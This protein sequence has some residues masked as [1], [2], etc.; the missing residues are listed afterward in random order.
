MKRIVRIIFNA[1]T[2]ILCWLTIS[3]IFYYLAGKWGMKKGKLTLMLVSPLFIIGYLIIL[4]WGYVTYLDY[5][6]KYYFTDEDRIERITGV[7][8]PDMDIVEYDKDKSGFTGDYSDRLLLEFEKIPSE[9]AYQTLDSLIETG[10]T[11]WRMNDSVYVF[12]ATWG[13]GMPTPK[14]ESE[15]EDRTFSISF[16][17]GSKRATINSGMW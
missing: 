16:K 10:K 14:G 8:L 4:F 11:G 5:E 17:K 2:C 6:R 12:S 9:G 15:D 1:I 13:N 3:P 7:R